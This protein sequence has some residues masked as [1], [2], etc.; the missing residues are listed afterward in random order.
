MKKVHRPK[1]MYVALA[2]WQNMF[3]NTR[4]TCE[5]VHKTTIEVMVEAVVAEDVDMEGS[6]TSCRTTSNLKLSLPTW[7]WETRPSHQGCHHKRAHHIICSKTVMENTLQDHC[8]I[9]RNWT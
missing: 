3:F 4:R 6:S 9:S 7:K 2:A 8:E 5:Y 1:E